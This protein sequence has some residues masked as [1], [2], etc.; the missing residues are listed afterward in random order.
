MSPHA[1]RLPHPLRRPP[2]QRPVAVYAIQADR[3]EV[4]AFPSTGLLM[5]GTEAASAR[6]RPLAARLCGFLVAHAPRDVPRDLV[7][8]HLFPNAKQPPSRLQLSRYSDAI[9]DLRR[10]LGPFGLG[11][12][13]EPHPWGSNRPG[14]VR[15]VDTRPCPDGT[16]LG[17]A[18]VPGLDGRG[19]A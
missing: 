4:R 15:L 8:A 17:Y 12:L 2:Q 3:G 19:A 5:V 16:V 7:I 6:V 13:N 10:V 9:A 11:I 1:S 18:Y 14:A